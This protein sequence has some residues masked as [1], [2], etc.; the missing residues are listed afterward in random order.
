MGRRGLGQTEGAGGAAARGKAD[1]LELLEL[2]LAGL[3]LGGL[4]GLGAET[5]DEALELLALAVLVGLGLEEL[6]VAGLALGEVVVQRA[7]VA[8]DG[9]AV[10]L[11]GDFGDGAEQVAVV[12]DE[13]Q[14]ALEAAQETLQPL[15]GGEV[16]VVGGLV[17]EE[18]LGFG[19]QHAG[20]LGAHAPAAGEGR[21]GAVE[22]FRGVAQAAEGFLHAGLEGVA[23][24]LLKTRVRLAQFAQE[25][26]LGRG[27]AFGGEGL[28][29]TRDVAL[30]LLE[31]RDAVQAILQE[32]LLGGGGLEVLAHKAD[33]RVAFVEHLARVGGHVAED[34]FEEGGLP[35]AVRPDDAHAFPGIDLE[36]GMLKERLRPISHADVTKLNHVRNY[37]KA[38]WLIS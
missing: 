3:R 1:L 2:L 8:G 12:R 15:H 20:E 32:R 25:A 13:G 10:D 30:G 22:V 24:H 23:A 5:L 29:Q 36:G 14:R 18:E 7:V 28:F 4:G 11:D 27:V 33:A 9:A 26:L 37:I 38:D 35:R 6:L 17:E 31:A 21:E 16:E 34:E 19:G